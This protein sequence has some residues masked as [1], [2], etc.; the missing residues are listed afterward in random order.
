M[1]QWLRKFVAF[2]ENS[3]NPQYLHGDSQLP[4]T[5]VLRIPT[6]SYGYQEYMVH[7]HI[8]GKNIHTHKILK[9][10]KIIHKSLKIIK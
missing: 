6:P 5:Q 4:I 9:T 3:V 10:N 1:A 2:A 7:K 8:C